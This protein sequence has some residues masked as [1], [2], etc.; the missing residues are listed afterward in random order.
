MSL[1]IQAPQQRLYFLP[2]PQGQG[3]LRPI[4]RRPAGGIADRPARRRQN[5]WIRET[6]KG[7]PVA[8]STRISGA[9]QGSCASSRS[10]S[11]SSSQSSSSIQSSSVVPSPSSSPSTSSS[12]QSSPPDPSGSFNSIT[13]SSASS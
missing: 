2:L 5:R 7:K 11:A 1:P 8:S 13:L 3:S 10:L 6:Q 4:L 12:S 9:S